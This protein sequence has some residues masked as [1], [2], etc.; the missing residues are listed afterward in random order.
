M[1]AHDDCVH[2]SRKQLT[3]FMLLTF[4]TTLLVSAGIGWYVSGLAYDHANQENHDTVD[5][6]RMQG[7]EGLHSLYLTE[8]ERCKTS[9]AT[10]KVLTDN[11]RQ[12]QRWY[13]Y[14]SRTHWMENEFLA[15]LPHVVV[16]PPIPTCKVIVKD[17]SKPKARAAH[18]K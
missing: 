7:R 11:A 12:Q 10:R 13:A 17:P 18:T 2:V 5:L 8:R 15:H 6:V 3:Y 1:S 4:L 16:P 14:L 9:T